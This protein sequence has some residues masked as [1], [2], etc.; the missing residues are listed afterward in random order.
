LTASDI[1]RTDNRELTPSQQLER[2]AAI[3]RR[4]RLFNSPPPPAKPKRPRP[5]SPFDARR[6]LAPVKRSHR[7]FLRAI[8]EVDEH[9]NIV[10]PGF[11]T[12]Q[13]RRIAREVA[14]KHLVSMMDLLSPRRDREVVR[15]RH[16]AFW[17]C[18]HETTMS[19]PEIGRRFGGRD[20]TTVLHGIR[21]HE[22]RM[23]EAT[24]A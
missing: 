24:D 18:K 6:L 14:A 11:F 9:E 2:I 10:I 19:L 3:E 5:M 22:E 21:K 8:E 13:W 20:H 4:R 15:A 7:L 17:R 23:R 16:E 12:P 1:Q